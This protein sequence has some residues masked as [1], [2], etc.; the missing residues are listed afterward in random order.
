MYNYRYY[1]KNGVKWVQENNHHE[2][3]SFFFSC[4]SRVCSFQH[5]LKGALH[6]N[7]LHIKKKKKNWHLYK[8]PFSLLT[9]LLRGVGYEVIF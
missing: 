7:N 8:H 4:L 6:E 9:I 3:L 1:V 5:M 2:F